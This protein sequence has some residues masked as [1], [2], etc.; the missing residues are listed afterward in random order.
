MITERRLVLVSNL[1]QE[2]CAKV[3][4]NF[5]AI[6]VIRDAGEI[7]RV[8]RNN[9]TPL[10]LK[11]NWNSNQNKYT[12]LDVPIFNNLNDFVNFCHIN[13]IESGEYITGKKI[14]TKSEDCFLCR[15]ARNC[16]KM[17]EFNATV[18]DI[19]DMIMYN[20]DNFFV[21][22]ELGCLKKGMVMIC[23]KSHVLSAANI[24]DEYFEEYLQ[25]MKD[26]EFILKSI[27]GNGP[28]IFFEHGSSPNGFSSH[29]RSIV[30]AHTHVAWGIQF[31]QHYLDM[32]SLT[33][34][35]DVRI[36]KNSKYF[37]PEQQSGLL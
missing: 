19:S 10:I 20:S 2:H 24:P 3:K 8:W 7:E 25:V 4:F 28:V 9:K 6:T 31:E 29:E 18:E 12:S 17:E 33:E 21:K 27:Y 23:P 15:I 13:G 1:S 30:H 35:P 36:S 26:V 14:D 34:V 16:E 11:K 5:E 37:S 22:I 32:V